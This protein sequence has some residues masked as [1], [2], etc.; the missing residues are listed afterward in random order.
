MNDEEYGDDSDE[1][2]VVDEG[3]DVIKGDD[4]DEGTDVDEGDN[5]NANY[6]DEPGHVKAL[7]LWKYMAQYLIL[8][9]TSPV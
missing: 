5:V 4:V 2:G 7:K 1:E 6:Y 8:S 9:R 3:D